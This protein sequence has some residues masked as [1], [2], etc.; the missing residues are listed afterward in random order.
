MDLSNFKGKIELSYWRHL[1]SPSSVVEGFKGAR[2]RVYAVFNGTTPVIVEKGY[3]TAI[4]DQA[5]KRSA[6]LL[7]ADADDTS[8]TV[9]FCL[10]T[11]F[12]ARTF[13]GWS[14][15]DIRVRAQG[16]DAGS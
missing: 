8:L 4:N 5:W 10:D 16:C 2:Y 12:G 13:A 14:L 6:F 1:H 3:D 7:D 11:G 9:S 15:D